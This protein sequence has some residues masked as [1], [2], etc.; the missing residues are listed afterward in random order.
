MAWGT[1]N[2]DEQRM[3][4]VIL[5]RQR[6]K[7]MQ[8]LCQE[9]EISRP[10]GYEWLRRYERG[11]I[12]GVVEKSRRP[13]H[14]PQRTEDG[15][16][17]RV[18]E[19]RQ[20]RPDWGAKKLRVLLRR[21]GVEVPRITIHRILMR[22]DLV[23]R[24]DRHRAAVKRF[25]RNRPNELWQMDFKGPM[26]WNAPTGPLSVLDD[27]SRYA[28]TLAE[29]GSTRAEPVRERLQEA[30]ERCGVPEGMLMHHGTPWWNMQAAA[31]WT[32]LTVWLMKQGIELHFSGYRHPQ[33]QGKVERFH[34]SLEAARRKRVESENEPPQSWYDAF[35][36]EYNQERPHEALGM[37]TPASVWC[38]SERRYQTN[39]AAWEYEAGAEV[40]RLGSQGQLT[41]EGKRWDISKAL[42][43]EWVQLIRMGER[44]LV[45]YCRSLVRELDPPHQRSTT[46]DRWWGGSGSEKCKGCPE[47]DL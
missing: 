16:E 25:E 38:P 44:I 42:T 19:M 36:Q 46:V 23:R 39:P 10:T 15:I 41:I 31:G 20:E 1:V 45:Y 8:Q 32:W 28:I 40:R 27:H 47:T 18:V 35:R 9:F 14:S 2:I 34:G 4:F 13:Q 6:E 21:E 43:G 3:R 24:Q 37:K 22:H 29:T 17:Q 26:G 12:A 7:T 30:F 5:A 33:T 11:G